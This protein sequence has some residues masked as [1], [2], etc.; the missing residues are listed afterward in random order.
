MSFVIFVNF[1]RLLMFLFFSSKL[2]N[3][4]KFVHLIKPQIITQ[5]FKRS[6][7]DAMEQPMIQ[8]TDSNGSS[9]RRRKSSF[10]TGAV[11]TLQPW[12]KLLYIK[13]PYPDNYTDPSFLSQL[14]RNTTVQ[15][16]P[17]WKLAG[18]FSLIS[19]HLS[20]LA[21]VHIVFFGMYNFNWDPIIPASL[22]TFLSLVSFTIFNILDKTTPKTLNAFKS[23]VLIMFSI[24][25][26]SP[27][28][29][30]L[31]ESTSSDSIWTLS[32][33]LLIC[34]LLFTDY[35]FDI[36]EKFKPV[37]SMNILISNVIVLASRLES[38]AAVFCFILFAFEVHGMFPFFDI[39]LRKNYHGAHWFLLFV[40]GIIV[41]FFIL[42][43][44]GVKVLSVWLSLHFFVV[45]V[46]PVY[47][48]ELQKYKNELQGPWDPAKPI[49]E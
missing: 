15:K 34:N 1:D 28:L 30:S 23:S 38:T 4:N 7:K 18:D 33:W 12:R 39:W 37:F 42:S 29:K 10:A 9:V 17:Y 44:G 16:Y 13:Q 24:L 2:T 47:F 3:V 48:L 36:N 41:D 26:L 6:Q 32:V 40:L 5:Y 19:L 43:M 11:S 25:T 46:C 27:V 49:I 31:S 8:I 35:H 22:G 21:I 20:T 14:K 45:L